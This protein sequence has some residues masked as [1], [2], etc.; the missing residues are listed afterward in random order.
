MDTASCGPACFS[1][2]GFTDALRTEA[3][4]RGDV[5]LIGLDELFLRVSCARLPLPLN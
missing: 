5:L 3:A 2:A 1:A 4:G